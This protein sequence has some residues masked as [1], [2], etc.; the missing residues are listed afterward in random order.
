MVFKVYARNTFSWRNRMRLVHLL[1]LFVIECI[2]SVD[3]THLRRSGHILVVLIETHDNIYS[4]LE[5]LNEIGFFFWIKIAMFFFCDGDEID[6]CVENKKLFAVES[7]LYCFLAKNFHSNL[8][9]KNTAQW[10][11]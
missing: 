11:I 1:H 5:F 9:Y 4:V 2:V 8:V 7:C 10:I 6:C 3:I